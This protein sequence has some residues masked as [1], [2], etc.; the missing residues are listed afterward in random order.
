[1]DIHFSNHYICIKDTTTNSYKD[2][3]V[4]VYADSKISFKPDQFMA[5]KENHEELFWCDMLNMDDNYPL[6]LGNMKNN[7]LHYYSKFKSIDPHW[8]EAYF[9]RCNKLIW[10]QL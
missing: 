6:R 3:K 10:F 5:R 9:D 2:E 8:L 1:M 7:K 4:K